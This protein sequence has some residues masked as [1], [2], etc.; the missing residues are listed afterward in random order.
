MISLA[1]AFK[2][3]KRKKEGGKERGKKGKKERKKQR[4]E[5]SNVN[6]FFI[7]FVL[8]SHPTPPPTPQSQ[9]HR[10]DRNFSNR[11]LDFVSLPAEDQ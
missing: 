2:V 5:R 7:S 8:C 4:E 6:V 9:L 11:G 3:T 1:F 10:F